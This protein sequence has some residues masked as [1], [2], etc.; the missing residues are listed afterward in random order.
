MKHFTVEKHPHIHVTGVI[1]GLVL[2]NC[3]SMTCVSVSVTQG[4][5]GLVI[6]DLSLLHRLSKGF[7]EVKIVT[8]FEICDGIVVICYHWCHSQIQNLV[9]KS[10]SLFFIETV[11]PQ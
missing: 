11:I 5:T 9:L 8:S 1:I 3:V 7:V 4:Q 10:A 2:C 6:R